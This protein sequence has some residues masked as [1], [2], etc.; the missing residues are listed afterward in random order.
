MRGLT[1]GAVNLGG[2]RSRGGYSRSR[3][4]PTSRRRSTAKARPTLRRDPRY[5]FQV[6]QRF[7]YAAVPIGRVRGETLVDDSAEPVRN[8]A[9]I[10]RGAGARSLV[11]ATR[12]AIAVS[13]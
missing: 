8:V 5:M 7:L 4:P 2:F 3:V 13:D 12:E 9:L 6:R 11:R 1:I 10:S